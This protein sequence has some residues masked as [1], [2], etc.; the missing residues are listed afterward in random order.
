MTRNDST[1]PV[2][3]ERELQ[4]LD[5]WSFHLLPGDGVG[6]DRVVIGTTGA[7]AIVFEGDSVPSGA[8]IPGLRRARRAARK[9]KGHLHAIGAYSDTFAVLCPRTNSV[10]APRTVRGVRVVPPVL[11]AG[12]ISQRN[13][14]AMPHQVR[15][16]AEALARSF[17]QFR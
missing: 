11:L 17:A 16:A 12:E 15:R 7:F 3:A 14:S 1:P 9:L 4:R 5:P 10:F 6:C 8:R 2:P 13:R